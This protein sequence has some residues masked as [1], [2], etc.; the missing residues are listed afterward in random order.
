MT[1]QLHLPLELILQIV[2]A[3]LPTGGPQFIA[4]VS[5]P[6]A[7]LLVAWSQVCRAT[8]EPATR[9]LRQHCIYIDSFARLQAFLRCLSASKASG[10]ASTLPPAIPPGSI[11]SIYLGLGTDPLLGFVGSLII[12]DL[13]VELGDSVR[14]LILDV[15]LRSL[16]QESGLDTAF[17]QRLSEGLSALS[18]VEEFVSVGGLPTLDFWRHES[19]FWE[20]WPK[21]R[22]LAGFQVN[23][24]EESLWYHV[25]RSRALEQV[26]ISRP[27]L[28]RVDRWNFKR[29]IGKYWR[30]ESGGDPTLARRMRI[31]L[32]D[33]EFTPSIIDDSE[34]DKNDP[35]GLVC[36]SKFDVPISGNSI[37]RT[38]HACR[39]W[40]I[41]AAKE[42][43]L[44]G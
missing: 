15:P 9:L 34:G 14:R 10:P 44:W 6:G 2:E 39:E 30:L 27:H 31:V 21:L 26:V 5:T 28:L 17:N 18:N 20:R 36:I 19:N 25:T 37:V 43:T 42:G 8:Y 11:S 35:M 29:A 32:A 3:S 4:N 12:R 41:Q 24:A 38:D 23:I 33:H 40:M 7:Q 1:H 13:L 16:D 22:R